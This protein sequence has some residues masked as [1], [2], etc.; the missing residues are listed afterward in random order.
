[1]GECSIV[2]KVYVCIHL[3]LKKKKFPYHNTEKNFDTKIRRL[4]IWVQHILK[5]A[6]AP[7][8]I[9]DYGDHIVF[10]INMNK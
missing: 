8:A 5:C 10:F 9:A 2:W 3:S 7:V 6:A 1:M 4:K